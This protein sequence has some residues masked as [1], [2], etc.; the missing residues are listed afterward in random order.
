MPNA[1][2]TKR[3][4]RSYQLF[5]GFRARLHT[6]L[7]CRR[8]LF[9]QVIQGPQ[10]LSHLIVGCTLIVF[11]LVGWHVVLDVRS[12][13]SVPDNAS[14]IDGFLRA[15]CPRAAAYAHTVACA[16]LQ[17]AS[18]PRPVERY[19]TEQQLTY[20]LLLQCKKALHHSTAQRRK[21]SAPQAHRDVPRP[22]AHYKALRTRV[23]RCTTR[24]IR[25]LSAR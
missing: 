25:T 6:E 12:C 21:R 11:L 5:R 3:C 2:F 9:M 24:S 8:K 10:L 20:F 15:H 23:R 4:S 18:E 13:N 17:R 1:V 7:C 16:V 14:E 22:R 19:A